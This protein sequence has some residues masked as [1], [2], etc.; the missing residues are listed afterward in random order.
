MKKAYT[1]GSHCDVTGRTY[2]LC[3]ASSPFLPFEWATATNFA[4]SYRTKENARRAALEKRLD[5][6]YFI[7]GPRGGEYP[8]KGK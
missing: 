5:G 6:P 2:V 8:V 3:S 4:F 1:I 7:R